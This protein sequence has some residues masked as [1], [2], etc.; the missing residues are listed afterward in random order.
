MNALGRELSTQLREAEDT[1]AADDDAWLAIYTGAGVR[2]F[3]AGRDLNEA[4]GRSRRG[5]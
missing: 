3:C 5:P 2:A 4:A 1:F